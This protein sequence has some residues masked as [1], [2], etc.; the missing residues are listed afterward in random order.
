VWEREP[1]EQLARRGQL[2]AYR[3]TGFWH[4]M[5]T[6]RDKMVLEE[7]WISGQAPWKVW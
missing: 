7:L 5:D 1:L 3:H 2:R 4:P 6:L